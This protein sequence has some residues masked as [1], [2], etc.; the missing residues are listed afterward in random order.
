MEVLETSKVCAVC[1]IHN[2]FGTLLRESCLRVSQN[3]SN[4]IVRRLLTLPLTLWV[5]TAII[6]AL[7]QFLSPTKRAATFVQSEQQAQN[8]ERI[9][10]QYGLDKPF[11]IQY[12]IWLREA[13][14]GNLGY[15]RTSNEL[16]ITTIKKRLPASVELA[17]YAI[18]P[19][20]GIGFW[21]GTTAALNRNKLIDQLLRVMAT[22][23][24]SLP[25]FLAA[26][27]FLII[28]YGGL[29][30]FGI[31]RVSSKFITEIA[32]GNISVPTGF[33]T[34]DA[35]LNRRFDLLIDALLHLI[36][37]V[38]T[39]VIVMNAQIMR[40][41]RSSLLEALSQDY[42]RTAKAK[43]LS[44]KAVNLKHARRNALIPVIT[45][46]GLTIIGLFNGVIVTEVV[47]NYKGLGS[48]FVAA[49]ANLDLPAVIGFALLTTFMVVLA[50]L[51]VDILYIIIDPRIRYD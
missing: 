36:L 19:V 49:A 50:N 18:L 48:W 44:A 37:P 22:L 26:I 9:I 33:M 5:I 40:V 14:K 25:V 30:W 6:F 31:G 16:V 46:S 45:L 41:M 12:G 47:F 20:I 34:I 43:G 32:N 21:L 51:V 28:F 2:F 10:T 29:G 24:W 35:I 39:L 15:S 7:L 17:L 4:F 23:G 38:I 8:I 13:L 27:W 1:A 11:Y 3:L 42:V